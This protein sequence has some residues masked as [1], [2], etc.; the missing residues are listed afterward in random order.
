MSIVFCRPCNTKLKV[1]PGFYICNFARHVN[2][3]LDLE[4]GGIPMDLTLEEH[5]L[6]SPSPCESSDKHGSSCSA[7]TSSHP[8]K[9]HL[10]K[11]RSPSISELGPSAMQD[12]VILIESVDTMGTVTSATCPARQQQEVIDLTQDP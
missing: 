12:Q 4:N 11:C 9:K 1:R 2:S 8:R 7:S 5:Q 6:D 3:Q 10:Q